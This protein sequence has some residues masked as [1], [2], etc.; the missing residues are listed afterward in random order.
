LS[1]HLL[2]VSYIITK[3]KETSLFPRPKKPIQTRSHRGIIRKIRIRDGEKR[4]NLN[5]SI[6][7]QCESRTPG[8]KAEEK[9]KC[10]TPGDSRNVVNQLT[11]SSS[12]LEVV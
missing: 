10:R 12:K 5:A 4:L 11:K 9:T 2:G 6:A 8:N 3:V 7:S 1:I